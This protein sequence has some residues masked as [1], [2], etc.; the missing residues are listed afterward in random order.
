MT[1]RKIVMTGAGGGVAKMLRPLLVQHYDVVLSDITDAPGD[2]VAGE[3]WVKADLTDRAAVGALLEGAYGLVHLGGQ[4]VEADWERVHAP[5][6]EGLWNVFEACREAGVERVIFASSNHA[7][8]FYPRVRKIGV[9]EPVRPDGI[10]GLS[11]AFGE[12]MGSLYADKHGLRVM[13]IRIGNIG[14]EPLDHRRLSIWMHP[15][16]L[17]QMIQ[18]GL[19]HPDIHHAIVYG[20]SHNERA[21]WDNATAFAL[22]Y[23]PKHHGE[24]HAAAAEA[25]QAKT[26]ADNI[27]DRFQ[28][29]TFCSDGFS[30]DLDRTLK[31]RQIR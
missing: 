11:K 19:E 25:G 9:Y 29:G 26:P 27:G 22:G 31:A 6:I 4:S 30:G 15:D 14:Y 16:D 24:D 2:L 23:E 18:I 13:S 7:V 10:Y 1:K 5:N 17:M 8:G 3:T 12:A 28:G 20:A 21:W